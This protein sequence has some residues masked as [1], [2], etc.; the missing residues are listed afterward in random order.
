[1]TLAVKICGLD[2]PAATHAAVEGG[3]AFVGF[4]FYPR[5]PRNL[6]PEAARALAGLVPT[7]IVKVGLFV[8]PDDETLSR[9][10]AEVPLDLIQLHG[11]EPSA[12][13]ADVRGRFGRPVMKVIKVESAE[14]LARAEPYTAVADR[15]LFDARPSRDDAEALPGGNARSFDWTLLR[16]RRWRL[17][18]ML[19][20]G[21]KVE[22]LAGAV[23]VSRA[24]AVDVSSGVEERPGVKSPEK[25]RAFLQEA[26][27][28]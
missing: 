21:L 5:S 22:N 26:A 12:R 8:D 17:P 27:R 9:T 1:M 4:V 28:L 14:D 20:G 3:A 13:V 7:G 16:G 24:P 15:L 2:S 18:W 10:L 25:I 11:E 19:A 6:R 23:R